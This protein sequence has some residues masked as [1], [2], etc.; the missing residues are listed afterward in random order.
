MMGLCDQADLKLKSTWYCSQMMG[1][2]CVT[3]AAD[4]GYLSFLTS[5]HQAVSVLDDADANGCAFKCSGEKL[6]VACLNVFNFSL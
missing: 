1:L 3:Q 2:K 4:L 5:P 6:Q